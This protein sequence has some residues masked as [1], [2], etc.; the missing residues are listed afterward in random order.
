MKKEVLTA[1][2]GI[3]LL[4][5]I[6]VFGGYEHDRLS[7]VTT[8]IAEMAFIAIGLASAWILMRGEES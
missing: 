1:I 2:V 4:G 7:A 6:G 3:C 5:M 8:S